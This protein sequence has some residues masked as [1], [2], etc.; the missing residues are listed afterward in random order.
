MKLWVTRPAFDAELLQAKLAA[1]GHEAVIEPLLYIDF[2]DTGILELHDV[3]ALITTSRNGVRAAAAA[4]QASALIQLPVFTVGPGTA[5]MARAV[6]FQTVIEGSSTVDKLLPIIKEN[7]AVK[8]GA[9]LHLAGETLAFDL[10]GKLR[11]MGYRV[12]QKTVYVARAA[13]QLRPSLLSEIKIGT[14]DGVILLSPRTAQTYLDLV[15]AHQVDQSAQRLVHFCLSKAVADK[16]SALQPHKIMI[17]KKPNIDAILMLTD[18]T[19]AQC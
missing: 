17:P 1:Q 8:G 15:L 2:K 7:A 4:R 5:A 11:S 18:Q 12:D 6:G 14:I 9:L 3:Q 10:T 19:T 16:V 13:R